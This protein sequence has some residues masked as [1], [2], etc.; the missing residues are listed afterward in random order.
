[1]HHRF[2]AALAQLVVIVR[3]ADRVRAPSDFEDVTFDRG[4]LC[5]KAIQLRFVALGQDAL[6]KS[7]GH[8]DSAD[9][10]VIVQVG[11]HAGQRIGTIDRLLRT[12][13]RLGRSLGRG[14]CVLG[15]SIGRCLRLLDPL[16]R[17][18]I[19]LWICR[20]FVAVASSSSLVLVISGVVCV[21]T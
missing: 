9:L 19:G 5:P 21:R 16:L 1:M 18:L 3:I 6:V 4:E 11:Y 2:G 17:T 14:G 10:L 7:K 13:L 15:G 8:R 12:T 20:L